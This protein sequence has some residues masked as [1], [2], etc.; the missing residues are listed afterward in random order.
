M[1]LYRKHVA[2]SCY[3]L[4][5]ILSAPETVRILWQKKLDL[6][7]QIELTTTS[8][9]FAAQFGFFFVSLGIFNW[10]LHCI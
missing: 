4:V 1:S 8:H 9:L 10:P 2:G 3:L 7:I 6:I 5:Q